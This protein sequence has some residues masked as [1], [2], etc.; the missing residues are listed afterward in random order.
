MIICFAIDTILSCFNILPQQNV[1]SS[2]THL[3]E[4]DS[5]R[6]NFAVSTS[7]Y[8]YG[9]N[10]NFLQQILFLFSKLKVVLWNIRKQKSIAIKFYVQTP[11]LLVLENKN[12][13]SNNRFKKKG[14]VKISRISNSKSPPWN[15]VNFVASLS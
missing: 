7:G 8:L 1:I 3:W 9:V 2:C 11:S 15:L 10:K 4:L 12:S 13:S 6:N 5:L 14:C